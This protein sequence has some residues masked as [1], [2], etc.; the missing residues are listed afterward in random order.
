MRF[1]KKLQNMEAELHF[2]K[3]P[4]YFMHVLQNIKYQTIMI[5]IKC[6]LLISIA[7]VLDKHFSKYV[8]MIF[9]N[10]SILENKF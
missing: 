2:L 4:F 1:L 10:L 9:Y 6:I 3:F 8:C 5:L 7:Y